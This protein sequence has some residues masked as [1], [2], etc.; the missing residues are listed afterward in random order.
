MPSSKVPHSW[1]SNDQFVVLYI[2][3]IFEQDVYFNVRHIAINM[4]AVQNQMVV[5]LA[6]KL[7]KTIRLFL[8][9]TWLKA[10]NPRQN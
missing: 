2:I 4:Y 1:T 3:A 10:Y 7:T 6:I 5:S 9:E 8:Q